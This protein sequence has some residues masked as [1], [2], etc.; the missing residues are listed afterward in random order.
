MKHSGYLYCS[1]GSLNGVHRGKALAE[2]SA[3]EPHLVPNL[4]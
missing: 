2:T 1:V 4:D 3:G